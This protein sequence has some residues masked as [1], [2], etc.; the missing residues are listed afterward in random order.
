MLSQLHATHATGPPTAS[1][2]S[3]AGP[4]S[5]GP[6]IIRRQEG[7]P[8]LRLLL[9]MLRGPRVG[10]GRHVLGGPPED[11]HHLVVG[12]GHQDQGQEE[13]HHHLVEG[14]DHTKHWHP[15]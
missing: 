14:N 2:L 4:D 8:A 12:G 6:L 11:G 9:R 5:E 3:E 7:L 13:Y 10:K 1:I 15:N